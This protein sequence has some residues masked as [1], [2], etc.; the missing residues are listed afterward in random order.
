MHEPKVGNLLCV[1]V[2]TKVHANHLDLSI[3]WQT[4]HWEYHANE[5]A[6]FYNF[7]QKQSK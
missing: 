6:G 7:L 4:S 3:N 1:S 5:Y 2:T